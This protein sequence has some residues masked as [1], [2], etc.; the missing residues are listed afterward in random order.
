M[1]IFDF[2]HLL[3]LTEL[4]YQEDNKKYKIKLQNNMKQ[5]Y[6]DCS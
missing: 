1:T 3:S 5:S 6:N 2:T 4:E